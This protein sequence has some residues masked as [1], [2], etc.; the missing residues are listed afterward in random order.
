MAAFV[1]T[2]L[3][4]SEP[5]RTAARLSL[6]ARRAALFVNGAC[7]CS[8]SGAALDARLMEVVRSRAA[9]VRELHFRTPSTSNET[10]ECRADASLR[11]AASGLSATLAQSRKTTLAAAQSRPTKKSDAR[12]F[13]AAALD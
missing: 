4:R 11:A 12:I 3:F 9:L 10:I 13:P 8:R 7:V 2:E 1:H 6:E 5:D